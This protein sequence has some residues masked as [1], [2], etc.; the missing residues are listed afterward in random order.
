MNKNAR[1]LIPAVAMLLVSA[2]ML[3]TASYAWF[4]MNNK[5]T[6]GGMKVN[7]T[8]PGDLE[9][10]A[11]GQDYNKTN[12]PTQVT[13]LTSSTVL[14][15]VSSINGKDTSFY[16]ATMKD[17]NESGNVGKNTEVKLMDASNLQTDFGTDYLGY[18]DYSFYVKNSAKVSKDITYA[19]TE[20]KFAYTQKDAETDTNNTINAFRY[21][22]FVGEKNQSTVTTTTAISKAVWSNVQTST[23]AWNTTKAAGIEAT[24]AGTIDYFEAG[25]KL[26]T[27]EAGGAYKIVVRIWLDGEDSLTTTNNFSAMLGDYSLTVALKIKE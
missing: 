11:D 10:S 21:T 13:S 4:S 1:K 3:S 12:A 8:T 6:A 22:I 9:I 15:P 20:C 23:A 18:V 7:V 16:Y 2:S 5:V 25:T 17:I 24:A 14:A 27:A 19:E 26:F